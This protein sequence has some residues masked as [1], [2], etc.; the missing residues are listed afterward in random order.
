MAIEITGPGKHSLIVSTPVMPSAGTVGF[1]DRYKALLDYQK[2]GAIVTN[3]VTIEPWN[4]A[5]GT[6]I[7]PLDAGVL[8]H[9]GLPNPGLAKAISQNRRIWANMAIPVILHLIGTSVDQIKRA[10]DLIDDTDEIAAVELGLS[11]DVSEAEAVGLVAA[12]S[13]M[14]KPLMGAFALLRVQSVGIAG[15]RRRSRCARADRCATRHRQRRAH[16]S[17]GQRTGIRTFDQADNPS[18]GG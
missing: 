2:L 9:T 5:S 4:P 14:E 15:R 13:R 6:R 3:P 12:A 11:D 1:G 10:I 7:I 16:R 17:S 8:V 18:N